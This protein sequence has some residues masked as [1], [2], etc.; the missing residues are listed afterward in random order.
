MRAR[1]ATNQA[2]RQVYPEGHSHVPN[3]ETFGYPYRCLFVNYIGR[4]YIESMV[5]EI[6]YQH[7]QYTR[8]IRAPN[9]GRRNRD[10]CPQ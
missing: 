8:L 7:V 4:S 6:W 9:L 1:K 5:R 3:I 10:Q 2:A